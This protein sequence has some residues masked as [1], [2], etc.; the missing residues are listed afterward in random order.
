MGITNAF[1]EAQRKI[2]ITKMLDDEYN[3]VLT[4][5]KYL[6]HFILIGTIISLAAQFPDF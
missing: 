3:P 2:D 6:W 5:H 1:P 4:I